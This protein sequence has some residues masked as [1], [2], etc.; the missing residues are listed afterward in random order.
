MEYQ[1]SVR[2]LIYVSKLTRELLTEAELQICRDFCAGYPEIGAGYAA[3]C[4]SVG[5]ARDGRKICR[6]N[7]AYLSA[8]CQ[9]ALYAVRNE[10]YMEFFPAITLMTSAGTSYA[11]LSMIFTVLPS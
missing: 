1:L 9:P 11:P 7:G 6:S 2:R 4:A 8:V 3:Q 10:L 5:A